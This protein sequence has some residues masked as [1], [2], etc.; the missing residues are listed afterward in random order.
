MLNVLTKTRKNFK[1]DVYF[2]ISFFNCIRMGAAAVRKS[3]LSQGNG[4]SDVKGAEKARL[5]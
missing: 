2:E 4:T 1:T 3:E 5:F